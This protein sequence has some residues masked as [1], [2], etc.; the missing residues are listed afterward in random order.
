MASNF[1]IKF[2]IGADIRFEALEKFFLELKKEKN[3]GYDA[4]EGDW[5]PTD[6]EFELHFFNRLD[7]DARAWYHTDANPTGKWHFESMLYSILEC[8]Y[9]LNE[10]VREG[11]RNGFLYYDPLAGPFGGTDSLKVLIQSFGHTVTFDSWNDS[12]R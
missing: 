12:A 1:Y 3:G 7:D 2:E 11:E 8:E 10:I 6:E 9:L 5:D 4:D